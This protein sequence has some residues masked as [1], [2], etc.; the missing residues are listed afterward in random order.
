MQQ[1]KTRC[2]IVRG[3]AIMDGALTPPESET[4]IGKTGWAQQVMVQVLDQN[5]AHIIEQFQ[6]AEIVLDDGTILYGYEC[7]W[8][9]VTGVE[10]TVQ[11]EA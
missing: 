3:E 8:Q 2:M 6:T 7:W 1:L 4:H 11:E 5:D 9:P 10:L